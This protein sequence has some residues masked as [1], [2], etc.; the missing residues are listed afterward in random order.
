MNTQEL[1][2]RIEKLSPKQKNLLALQFKAQYLMSN[3]P[4]GHGAERLVAYVIGDN[5]ITTADFRDHL[6]ERLPEYMIPAAFVPLDKFPR[7]PNGKVDSQ[8]LPDAVQTVEPSEVDYTAPRTA[9]EEKLAAIWSEAL[10]F[11]PVGIHDNFFE[12]GGDS[13]L[14][15][16]IIAKAGKAGI[17]LKPN[18]IFEHQ[19]IAE[20]ALSASSGA[21]RTERNEPITGETTVLPIQHW[22]FEEHKHAPHHWN[23]G[24]FFKDTANLDAALLQEAMYHLTTH[25]DALRLTFVKDQEKW[26]ASVGESQNENIFQ[27]IDLGDLSLPEQETTIQEKASLLQGELNLSEGT[28]CQGVYFDC[29]E[30][31]PDKFML[32]AHHLVVDAVS[33][34]ILIED[35][36]TICQQLKEG[37]EV[38]L[39]AKTTSFKEWG[40]HLLQLAG[41]DQIIKEYDFWQ[42][43]RQGLSALP[44]DFE[45]ALPV[46]EESGATINFTLDRFN[47]QKLRSEALTTYNTRIDEF[48][49]AVLTEVI[50]AWTGGTNICIGL[51]RHGRETMN[52]SLDLSN[53]VGWFTSYFPVSLGFNT[54]DSPETVLKS[55]K[56]Q[57]RKIPNGGI[58]YGV[59]RYM[60]EG[61]SEEMNS[62]HHPPIIFN[63][64][65][66]MASFNA[67][68]LGSAE[69]VREGTRH[70][71]S[72]R[73][74]LLEINTFIH[75]DQLNMRWGYS[76][77][78]HL[79]ESIHKLVQ[80]FE[81]TL[82]RFIEHCSAPN[83]GGFTPSDFPEAGLNQDDLD[84]LLG[85]IDQ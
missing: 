34:G 23:Q 29:G 15:I 24:L 1:I 85:E 43:Q 76:R 57:L 8:A 49:L 41:T 74:H 81:K 65:G 80:A 64:L 70:P 56:E 6:K 54:A 4:N 30:R 83:A 63:Y 82:L 55:V 47:T 51:E 44:L 18:S 21:E 60:N 7:L 71:Q 17:V 68:L 19:T 35:L 32:F 73:Y 50:G 11:D 79:P 36:K 16:Q 48:L 31:Q 52:T 22:F 59:L 72:E 25:H 28:L 46:R 84:S 10:N 14:S 69:E 39:P 37:S 77:Q 66:N 38:S 13:I 20:L 53:T 5:N 27:K 61:H 12:I 2:E 33:W 78:L 3:A 75:E 9:I 62:P 67:G 42:T 40:A 58:G 26:T 45:T